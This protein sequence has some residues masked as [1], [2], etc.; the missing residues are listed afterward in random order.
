MIQG[1][2]KRL[3][4]IFALLTCLLFATGLYI[5]VLVHFHHA[6]TLLV[7][8]FIMFAGFIAPSICYGYDLEGDEEFLRPPSMNPETFANCRDFGWIFCVT[9]FL[10][11]YAVPAAA[12]LYS[13]GINPRLWAV[14][15]TYNAHTLVLWAFIV[16]IRIFIIKNK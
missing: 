3:L 9:C 2:H 14:V 8:W 7:C 1:R 4:G 5:Y 11:T 13:D 6:W 16:W 12:W 10:V 15:C